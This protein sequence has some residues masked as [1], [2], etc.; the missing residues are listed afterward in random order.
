M[1]R[2]ATVT[3]LGR[4][5]FG[6]AAVILGLGIGACSERSPAPPTVTWDWSQ[7]H[8]V[9]TIGWPDD[10]AKDALVSNVRAQLEL[11]LSDTVTISVPM[12][13]YFMRRNGDVLKDATIH[14]INI[15]DAESTANLEQWVKQLK[16]GGM[17]ADLLKKSGIRVT[18]GGVR[19]TAES[20]MY[21]ISISERESQG[22]EPVFLSIEVLWK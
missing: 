11:R 18:R 1:Q 4:V 12:K 16:E 22:E 15:T 9:R 13:E 17:K 10:Q 3:A 21:V 14:T 2:R 5:S 7:G 6:A 8:G 20:S 19:A